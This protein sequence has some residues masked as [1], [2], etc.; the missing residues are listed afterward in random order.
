MEALR[1]I[2]HING[3]LLTL[4]VPP[5]LDNRDVEVIVLP[6]EQTDMRLPRSTPA[7]QR[8]RL[9]EY[10]DSAKIAVEGTVWQ[11]SVADKH[12]SS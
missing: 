8:G 7:D 3:R 12:A 6:V 1:E 10:A 9:R 2:A 11:E 4:T 5:G